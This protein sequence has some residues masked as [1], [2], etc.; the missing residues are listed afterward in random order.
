MS[1]KPRLVAM[2]ESARGVGRPHAAQMIALDLLS[3]AGLE[4]ARAPSEVPSAG[5][6]GF[7][8]PLALGGLS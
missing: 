1:A 8:P 3:L 5:K 2:A 7:E 6:K 4:A